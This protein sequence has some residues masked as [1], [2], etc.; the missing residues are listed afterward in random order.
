MG[1]CIGLPIWGVEQHELNNSNFKTD[2]NARAS[3]SFL[4]TLNLLNFAKQGCL[5]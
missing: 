3:K 1:P 5:Y 4:D 2:T